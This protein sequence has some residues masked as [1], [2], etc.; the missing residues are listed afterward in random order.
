[1]K[2]LICALMLFLAQ[3]TFAD[4][5]AAGTLNL[6]KRNFYERF[7][8]VQGVSLKSPLDKLREHGNLASPSPS[9]FYDFEVAE[10]GEWTVIKLPKETSHWMHHNIT[11]WFL[12]WGEGDP[13]HADFVIGLAKGYGG[14]GYTIYGGNEPSRPQDSLYGRTSEGRSFLI[15]IPFDELYI[16]Y[17]NILPPPPD[18][19]SFIDFPQGLSFTVNKIEY[20]ESLEQKPY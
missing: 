20:H 11:Y 16:D 10:I 19:V 17:K 7:V 2:S 18:I 6:I 8:L 14:E 9:V 3:T 12:G 4:M 1:M 13:N 5:D 15:N